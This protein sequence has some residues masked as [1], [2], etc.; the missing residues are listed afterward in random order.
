MCFLVLVPSDIGCP[1][2]LSYVGVT[3]PLGPYG[4]VL[5]FEGFTLGSVCA[6]DVQR[7]ECS[8]QDYGVVM[9]KCRNAL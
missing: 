5:Q 3:V 6:S 9:C 7:V 8:Q 2:W 1:F 4:Q